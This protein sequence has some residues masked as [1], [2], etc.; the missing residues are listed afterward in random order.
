VGG[1]EAP[2]PDRYE[3]K[4][5]PQTG[6]YFNSKFK[7]SGATR[8]NPLRSASTHALDVKKSPSSF[9]YNLPELTTKDGKVLQSKFSSVVSKTFGKSKRRG[10]VPE[11]I[12]PGP[13][14]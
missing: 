12:T 9:H 7:S 1:S 11:I 5:L 6:N 13:G 10:I 14:A 4:G 2:S 3:I 8:F